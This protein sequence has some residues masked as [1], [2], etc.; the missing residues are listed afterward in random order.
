[1]AHAPEQFTLPEL[2]TEI[3]DRLVP[4]RANEIEEHLRELGAGYPGLF[5][6]MIRTIDML[7][8]EP[9][10]KRVAV[11]YDEE[12]AL[13][14]VTIWARTTFSLDEWDDRMVR[15]DDR[16]DQ[17]LERFPELVLVAIL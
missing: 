8:A 17:I 7:E 10:M 9:G 5:D 2:P 13:Y 1:M 6:A 11:D 14:P 15:L 12:D 16:A 4:Y 3:K